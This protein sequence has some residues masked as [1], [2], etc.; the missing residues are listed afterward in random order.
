MGLAERRATKEF[1]D[2]IFPKLKSDILAAAGCPVEIAV[3]WEKLAA[4]EMSHLYSETWPKVYFKPV[5]EGLKSLCRDDMGK[6]A[7][8]GSLKKIVFT[9]ESQ[10]SS[11]HRWSTF[12][13]GVL[14]LDHEPCTN[15]DYVDD[16]TDELV[17]L[18]EKNL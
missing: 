7:V 4:P 2:D 17:K 18:L 11:A 12:A 5:I 9:N 8:K 10:I 6:E 15:V 13:G 3:E 1:Q 14:R 16:R